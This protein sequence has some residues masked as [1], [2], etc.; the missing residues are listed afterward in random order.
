MSWHAIHGGLARQRVSRSGLCAD[1][2]RTSESQNEKPHL[3]KV[4]LPNPEWLSRHV[5]VGR[6]VILDRERAEDSI[7]PH[8]GDLLLHLALHSAVEVDV[9]IFHDDPDR[10]CRV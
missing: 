7:S 4:G 8:A 3:T 9:P 2:S 5:L 1:A 6:K 10:H